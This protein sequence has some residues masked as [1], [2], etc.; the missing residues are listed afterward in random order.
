[1]LIAVSEF[2]AGKAAHRMVGKVIETRAS[3]RGGYGCS[4][5][6]PD[7][8]TE[9]LIKCNGWLLEVRKAVGCIQSSGW[10]SAYLLFGIVLQESNYLWD[11]PFGGIDITW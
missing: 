10:F 1:M 9:P 2:S 4:L 3:T 5:G 8:A 6:D 7:P 11:G